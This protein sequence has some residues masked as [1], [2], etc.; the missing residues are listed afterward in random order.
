MRS[1]ESFSTL[2]ID[3]PSSPPFM[4]SPTMHRVVVA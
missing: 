3:L 1:V 4:N 2:A